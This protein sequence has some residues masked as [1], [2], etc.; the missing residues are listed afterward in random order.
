MAL[1]PV[2]RQGDLDAEPA[3]GMR[4]IVD[5][6]VIDH[7]ALLGIEADR[8]AAEMADHLELQAVVIGQEALRAERE[9]RL[10]G[11]IVVIPGKVP[12]KEG[13]LL[14]I[15][16]ESEAVPLGRPQDAQLGIDPEPLV[17][18]PMRG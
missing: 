12:G 3:V 10:E 2:R 16:P 18:E 13:S 7:H 4:S 1:H 5:H 14:V 15:I 17:A 8:A 9:L 6:P 11:G